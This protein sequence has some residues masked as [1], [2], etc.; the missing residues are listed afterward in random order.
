MDAESRSKAR[1]AFCL[2]EPEPGLCRAYFEHYHYNATA[3]A[4]QMFV[5]GGCDGNANR[6]RSISQCEQDCFAGVLS[7]VQDAEEEEGTVDK[8]TVVEEKGS[9][10]LDDGHNA[11]V[12]SDAKDGVKV[13]EGSKAR[14]SA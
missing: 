9:G 6:F 3:D 10:K 7:G 11:G 1:P 12:K 14:R 4:C 2:E 8:N 13:D 5:Y